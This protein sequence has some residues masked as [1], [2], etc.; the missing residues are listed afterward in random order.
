MAQPGVQ[1]KPVELNLPQVALEP[2]IQ[3]ALAQFKDAIRWAAQGVHSAPDR[4]TSVLAPAGGS[5]IRPMVETDTDELVIL[6]WERPGTPASIL[7]TFQHQA[8][9]L[10]SVLQA[11]VNSGSMS[12][13]EVDQVPVAAQILGLIGIEL[14]VREVAVDYY[15]PQG[16][17]VEFSRGEGLL[18]LWDGPPVTETD[19]PLLTVFRFPWQ[20][21]PRRVLFYSWRLT[22][23]TDARRDSLPVADL[24]RLKPRGFD[25][26]YLSADGLMFF[27]ALP[28]NQGL[29]ADRQ[30]LDAL[31]PD[32]LVVLDYPL[33]DWCH[34]PYWAGGFRVMG[35]RA[36]LENWGLR[37]VR[38]IPVT[39]PVFGYSG[40]TRNDKVCV[41][42]KPPA[43]SGPDH[44]APLDGAGFIAIGPTR[45][46]RLRPR[47]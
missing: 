20:G 6:S 44:P 45:H 37:L 34:Q 23:D 17:P 5:K 42:Q 33:G 1:P 40:I 19:V 11:A 7:H 38:T 29:R 26:G 21:R 41:Y 25:W 4:T 18:S 16:A 35:G 28:D 15:L 8:N 46:F 12:T 14:A 43:A 22:P 2:G 30:M 32:G 10:A 27:S 9:I 47:P 24:R 13:G 36:P 3:A 39:E 31:A